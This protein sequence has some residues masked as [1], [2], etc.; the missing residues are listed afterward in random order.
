[1]AISDWD[2]VEYILEG[3]PQLGEEG[4][5][6]IYDLFC[7]FNENHPGE[8]IFPSGL[9]LAMGFSLDKS[10][11]GLEGRYIRDEVHNKDRALTIPFAL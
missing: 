1:M 5:R 11:R 7:N 6:T 4:W 2:R 3:K 10:L 8:S 9:C